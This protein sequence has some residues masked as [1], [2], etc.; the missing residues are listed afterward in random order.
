MARE[1][2]ASASRPVEVPAPPPAQPPPAA[3]DAA[4]A[5]APPRSLEDLVALALSRDPSTRAAWHDARAAAAQ[6]GG[7]RGAYLPT[8]DVNGV[9][10][11][12]EAPGTPR[13]PSSLSTT[14]GVNASISWL[15]LDLGQR[16]AIVRA[17]D[18]LALAASLAHRATVQDLVLRVQ[19]GYYQYL[20]A[21]GLVAAQQANVQAA[22][23]NLAAADD[24]RRAGVAT[25]ADVLQARTAASQARLVLQR[26]EGNAL[27][28]RGQ[29]AT[30]V[31]LAPT[32]ELEVGELPARVA[33]DRAAPQVD[34]LLADATVHSPDLARARALA[35]A[36]D[37]EAT[38]ASRANLPTLSA[39]GGA[40][41]LWYLAPSAPPQDGWSAG[42]VL[43]V[44]IFRGLE[45]VY[46]SAAARESA[47]AAHAR[48]E[49]AAQGVAIAVWSSYQDVRTAVRRVETSRDLLESAA[50]SSE[51]ASA[52]YKEGVGSILDLLNAQSALAVARAEDV[53]ARTDFFLA[54]ASLA[55]ATG[56]LEA[57][58]A[59]PP[60]APDAAGDAAGRP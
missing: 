9:F 28:V 43:S 39:Q 34:A 16:S 7:T 57:V 35:E 53:T 42:L 30:L 24:R 15:L 46:A 25:I 48:A 51:V 56:R 1:A 49:S 20:A 31:G 23:T 21:R 11:R 45:N 37:A 18:R 12:A 47:A 6:A 26:F 40:S 33:V 60:A 5:E 38:A 52:R 22:Q 3:A 32:S 50:A 55:R 54:L 41:R 44:P 58:P 10:G 8:L 13:T 17:S 19:Q 14:G 36:A 4:A 2:P 29:L 59:V 27:V